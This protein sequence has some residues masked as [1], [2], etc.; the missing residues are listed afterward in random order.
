MEEGEGLRNTASRIIL[1]DG[2]ISR[3]RESY[4]C[5]S[6]P[7]SVERMKKR[8]DEMDRLLL[9][10][11]TR[12]TAASRRIKSEPS[13]PFI[14]LLQSTYGKSIVICSPSDVE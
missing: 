12:T 10:A 2:C 13:L 9:C 7:V 8:K 14:L 4:S 11:S 5:R 6:G 3:E 1:R